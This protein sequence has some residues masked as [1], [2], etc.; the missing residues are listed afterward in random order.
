MVGI[1]CSRAGDKSI[2]RAIDTT[3]I[4]RLEKISLSSLASYGIQPEYLT[5]LWDADEI[6]RLT[7]RLQFVVV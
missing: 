2:E 7:L 4:E 6:I 1:V 3:Y 5:E